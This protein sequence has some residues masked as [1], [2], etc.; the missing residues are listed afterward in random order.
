MAVYF[1]TLCNKNWSDEE[2][3]E[4]AGLWIQS[5]VNFVLYQLYLH[6]N[7]TTKVVQQT[8]KTR[9]KL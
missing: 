7:V 2:E 8:E 6:M 4:E 1:F 9:Y 3:N 5:E